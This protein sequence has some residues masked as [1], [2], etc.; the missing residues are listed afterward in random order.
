MIGRIM[1][2]RA[3]LTLAF[4][5]LAGGA[6]GCAKADGDWKAE[7]DASL[8][9]LA[10]KGA[11]AGDTVMPA[12]RWA[13]RDGWIQLQLAGPS[14]PAA[15]IEGIA[16]EGSTL[17]VT[18][19]SGREGFQTMDIELVQ[20]RLSGGDAES[21]EEVVVSRGGDDAPADQAD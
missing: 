9:V 11:Q 18:V 2:R 10:Q 15:E 3:A 1:T 4:V 14:L 19:G 5:A 12:D 16:Q 6:F 20:F 17:R 21:I 8:G 13:K 7:E